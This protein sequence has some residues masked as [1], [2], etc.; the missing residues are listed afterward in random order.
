M[1]KYIIFYLI[2]IILFIYLIYILNNYKNKSV[3]NFSNVN[4]ESKKT[5]KINDEYK[6]LF[7]KEQVLNTLRIMLRDIDELFIKNNL[8]Y[9]IDGGTLL[10]AVRHQDIIPW[11]DDADICIFEKDEIILLSLR[12]QLYNLGY[13]MTTF[14]GGYKIFPINGD[15]IESN[16]VF[17][18]NYPFV[19]IFLITNIDDKYTYSN[20]RVKNDWPNGYYINDELLPLKRYKFNNFYLYGPNNAINYL[21]RLYGNDWSNKAYKS[22]DHSCEEHIQIVNFNLD[23]KN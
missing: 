1:N 2:L 15:K 12:Y 6:H 21:D 4:E 8:T 10:G 19:D 13:E 9:W 20:D 17:D 7:V 23:G 14:W 16:D 5:I 11:D 18:Y 3:N 22:Y